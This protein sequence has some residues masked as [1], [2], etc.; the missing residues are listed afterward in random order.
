MLRTSIIGASVGFVDV[1]PTYAAI[2]RRNRGREDDLAVR[3][4]V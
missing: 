1:S 3:L 4:P 2:D